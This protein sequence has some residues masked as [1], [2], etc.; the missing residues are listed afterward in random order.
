MNLIRG[1]IVAKDLIMQLLKNFSYCFAIEG[2]AYGC[3]CVPYMITAIAIN[4]SIMID[5]V[6]TVNAG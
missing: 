5:H 1:A 3:R 4:C 6:L 2:S